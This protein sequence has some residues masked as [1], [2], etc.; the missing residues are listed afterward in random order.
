MTAP[1]VLVIDGPIDHADVVGLCE[2]VRELLEPKDADLV[3]CDVGRL[4][5]TGLD[6][7]ALLAQLQLAARRSGGRIQVTGASSTLR[8]VL[9]LAGLCDVLGAV[10]RYA[11]RRGGRPNIG[12]KRAVSRKNVIPLIRSPDSS[13]TCTDQGSSPPSAAGLY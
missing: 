12:K 10:P 7:V 4:D 2:R 6:A 8:E 11:S 13:R 3:I 1:P 9:A 5:A